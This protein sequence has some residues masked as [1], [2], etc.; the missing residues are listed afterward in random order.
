MTDPQPQDNVYKA[1]FA[2]LGETAVTPE[3]VTLRRRALDRFLALG[4]PTTRNEEW[5]FTSVAPIARTP[6][7]LAGGNGARIDDRVLNGETLDGRRVQKFVP[8]N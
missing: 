5:R 7:R 8:A 1:D 4:F 2:R 3:L 6:F